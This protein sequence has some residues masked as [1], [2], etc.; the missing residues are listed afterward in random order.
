MVAVLAACGKGADNKNVKK[1]SGTA[2]PVATPIALPTLGVDRIPR[3]NFI[4]DDGKAAFD[5]A[6]AAA[7][8][9]DWAEVKK[10][11]ELSLGK[12]PYHLDA[13]RL[14][15]VALA[16][17]GDHAAAVDHLVTAIAADFY[18]YGV[19]FPDDP[20]LEG[21]RATQHGQAVN[22]LATQIRDELAKRIAKGVVFVGR[23]ASFRYG[24][25]QWL[26]SRGELY[27]FDRDTRRYYRL[28]HTNHQVAGFVTAPDGNEVALLG[29][30]KGEQGND[31]KPPTIVRAWVQTY[32][33]ATWQATTS[34]ITFGPA[35]AIAVQYAPDDQLLVGAAP[36]TDRWGLGEWTVSA[37]D[38]E[39]G[40]LTKVATPLG[41]PRIE[42]T[43]DEGRFVPPP[44]QGVEASW[45]G[46]P[47]RAATLGVGGTAIQIPESGQAALET[48]ALAPGGAHLAFA[49]AV[50]P[51]A[52]DTAPSLYV[53]DT[54]T[55]ALKHILTE[56]SRFATQW[57]DAK[58][59]VYLDG[60]DA[61]RLWDVTTGREALR[62]ENRPGVA[63]AVLS[64]AAA[65]LC[66]QAPPALEDAASAGAADE[67]PPEEPGPVTTP[68]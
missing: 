56:K 68:Q 63:L 15:A 47:A 24:R 10:Q 30:D 33:P 49:T 8:K 64:R 27:A 65:P 22:Q 16:Q 2:A 21:F 46:D 4:F 17:T 32:D 1:D 23:R 13:H 18:Q 44:A 50:D 40:T 6:E 5:K 26:S 66:K 41:S 52:E 25:S 67:M 34:K 36:A 38:R 45:T 11:A 48:V 3:F 59:L 54:K 62:I 35:R 28:T 57:L 51:C 12:D 9:Q 61:I 42:L 43:L 37:V 31:G 39:K 55:G 14:L 7:K 20:L 60:N 58:T 53:A 29:F 19:A